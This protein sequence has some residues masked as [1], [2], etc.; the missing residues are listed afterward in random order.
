LKDAASASIYGSRLR[1][2]ILIT[3]RGKDGKPKIDSKVYGWLAI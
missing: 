2:V 3:K 1:Q